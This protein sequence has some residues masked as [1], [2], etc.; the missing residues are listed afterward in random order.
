MITI[1]WPEQG[2]FYKI[3]KADVLTYGVFKLSNV[4]DHSSVSINDSQFYR[5]NKIGKKN[6][7]KVKISVDEL[8]TY[9]SP[10]Q[11]SLTLKEVLKNPS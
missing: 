9:G 2:N 6:T 11:Q 3:T 10:N 8:V 5:R 7:S 1:I 4:S